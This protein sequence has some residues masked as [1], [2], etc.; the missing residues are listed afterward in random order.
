VGSS[1]SI[2]ICR[3]GEI[4]YTATPLGVLMALRGDFSASTKETGHLHATIPLDPKSKHAQ[5]KDIR[6]GMGRA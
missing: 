6:G 4:D 3:T 1:K 5:G 2:T